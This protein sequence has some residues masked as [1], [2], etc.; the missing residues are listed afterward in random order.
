MKQGIKTYRR[1]NFGQY[2][3]VGKVLFYVTSSAS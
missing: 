1:K 2:D 3:I